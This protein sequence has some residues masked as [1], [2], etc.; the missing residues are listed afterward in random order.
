MLSFSEDDYGGSVKNLLFPKTF[1]S[2]KQNQ[3]RKMFAEL[4]KSLR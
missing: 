1:G 3:D 4:E 2:S